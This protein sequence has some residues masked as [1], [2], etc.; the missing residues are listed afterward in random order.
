MIDSALVALYMISVLGVGIVSGLKVK[1]LEEYSVAKGSFSTFVLMAAIF[2]TLVGGGSTMG[3]SEK[4]FSTGVVFL[5]ACLSFVV[6]DLIIAFVFVPQF[7]KFKSCLTVGDIMALSYGKTGKICVG[8]AGTLQSSMYLSM[9]LAAVGHLLN[10]F[11]GLPYW[12]GILIGVGIVV[13]YSSFGGI[14]AVTL[15]DVIQ[16]SVLIVAIPVT[17]TIGLDMVGGFQGI[18]NSVPPEK[19]SLT[20][21]SGDEIRFYSLLVV[22][23]LPYLNPALVQRLL[24]GKSTQ[25]VRT[26]LIISALGRLPYYFMVGILGLVAYILEPTLKADLAFPYLVNQI[27]PVGVKGL[28][29]S[30]VM[31]VI[32]STADSFLHVAGLLLTHDVIKPI[33]GKKLTEKHELRLIRF[34]TAIIGSIALLAAMTNTN[35]IELNILAYVF[36]LPAIFIPLVFGVF[37]GKASTKIFLISGAFGI[38]TYILWKFF[39]YEKT[40]IDSLLPAVVIN[41]LVFFGQIIWQKISNSS[42]SNAPK[43]GS[44]FWT[45]KTLPRPSLAGLLDS[46]SSLFHWFAKRSSE[47]VLLFGAPYGLFAL[48]A[49]TNLCILPL[50]FSSSSGHI[51]PL[52]IIYLRVFACSLS[53]VLVMK[54]FWPKKCLQFL[55]MYWHITLFF[56]L[57]FFTIS[58]C[59]FTSCS[60]EWVID[61]VLTNFILGLLV[62][63]KTYSATITIA[64]ILATFTFFCFG[65]L[66]QFDPNLG[67]FPVMAYATAVS[68]VLG[69]LFSRSRERVLQDKILTFK[70]LGSTIAH[71]MRTPLSSINI[72]A[73]G[74][75]E[76]IPALVDGYQQAQSAGIKVQKIPKLTLESLASSPKRMR[77]I[78]ASTLNVI[79]MILLQLKDG[80]WNAYFERC[81][82]QECIDLALSEFC[83]RENERQYISHH[84]VYDFTFYGNKYLV[85]HILFNLMRNSLSF[86]HS[87]NKGHIRLWTSRNGQQNMLH[88]YDTAK[89]IPAAEIPHIFDLGYSNRRLGSGVGLHYCKRMMESMSGTIAVKSEEGTF[90][91]FILTFPPDQISYMPPSGSA[92]RYA[93][94]GSGTTSLGLTK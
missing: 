44:N 62:D 55:P 27:L 45:R 57:P 66:A 61:L 28:V 56:C 2:A 72:S 46:V 84:E 20:P 87:E 79:D 68:L 8:I 83:F 3:V 31:A 47:R 15:T 63:W 85:V 48:F 33:V 90:T 88:F 91:E 50:F 82:M 38:A 5:L 78:C 92:S 69:A 22:F 24:M 29:I 12:L 21:S 64:S 39:W 60:I 58:M 37:R 16:F 51:T 81:S 93:G 6:R 14:K 80:D 34:V 4:V 74:L 89:G 77:Y 42:S 43:T 11:M 30:G 65:D 94:A 19:L 41:G 86:I 49:V 25:Q 59:L 10:Y 26:A 67:N 36:W 32:M 17:F 76:L 52:F 71:E 75:I 18:F 54:D 40:S 73:H 13:I 23:V 1:D 9:Q 35:I 7:D 53:F 70:A